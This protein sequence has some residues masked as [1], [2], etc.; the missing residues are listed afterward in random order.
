MLIQAR[1]ADVA[2]A[3]RHARTRARARTHTQTH[4]YA[5]VRARAHAQAHANAHDSLDRLGRFE[6]NLR[7]TSCHQGAAAATL[8]AKV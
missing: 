3:C 2:D 4:T 7:I 6:L 8:L 5:Q 1:I